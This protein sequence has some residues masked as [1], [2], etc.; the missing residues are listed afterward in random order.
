MILISFVYLLLNEMNFCLLLLYFSFCF[1]TDHEIG[2][3]LVFRERNLEVFFP[4][5]V[6]PKTCYTMTQHHYKYIT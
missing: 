2:I 5:S 4:I 3:L 1:F 6:G